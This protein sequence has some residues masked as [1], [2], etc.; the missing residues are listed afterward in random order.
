MQSIAILDVDDTLLSWREPFESWAES[1]GLICWDSS[2]PNSIKMKSGTVPTD[3]AIRMF[4]Q[5]YHMENLPPMAGAQK[6]VRR[7]V[8]E[9]YTLKICTAFSD[10]YAAQKMRERNLIKHFGDVFSEMKFVPLNGIRGTVDK[11]QFFR[12]QRPD[13]NHVILFEDNP[14]MID[15][16]IEAGIL[17][18]DCVM[19]PRPFNHSHVERLT[20]LGV[21][22]ITW[23]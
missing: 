18:H 3:T 9:G 20:K 13:Q 22:C 23:S 19:I 4:N 10:N 5:T 12:D 14:W 8:E 1:H 16:A 7:L 17:A 11:A 15:A 2:T 6:A 21:R